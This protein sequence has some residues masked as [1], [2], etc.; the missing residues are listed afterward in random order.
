MAPF[1]N[2]FRQITHR[3]PLPYPNPLPSHGSVDVRVLSWDSQRGSLAGGSPGDLSSRLFSGTVT[4]GK[5]VS[6]HNARGDRQYILIIYTQS[7]SAGENI[8]WKEAS[9]TLTK[10][11]LEF[12]G[13]Y[14]EVGDELGLKL[15]GIRGRF[16]DSNLILQ[17]S[18]QTTLEST[19]VAGLEALVQDGS[20]GRQAPGDKSSPA[21]RSA[22]QLIGAVE[23]YPGL[24]VGGGWGGE[25]RGIHWLFGV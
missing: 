23:V 17:G 6:S 1:L 24:R 8:I 16:I 12:M 4:L 3:A 19:L 25:G 7:G 22:W 5:A 18:L 20:Q 9:M 13:S 21:S 14:V 11:K 10:P 2:F 15:A